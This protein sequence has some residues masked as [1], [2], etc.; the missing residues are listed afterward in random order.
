VDICP[1]VDFEDL[2]RATYPRVLAYGRSVAAREDAEDAVAEAYSIAW[3]RQHD[4][5]C[6]RAATR[7]GS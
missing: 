5:R 4:T 7:P 1:S 6:C 3:R 2:Y